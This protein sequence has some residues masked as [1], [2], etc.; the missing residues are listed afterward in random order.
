MKK[1]CETVPWP[2]PLPI[3]SFSLISDQH[4]PTIDHLLQTLILVL[5]VSLTKL[6]AQQLILKL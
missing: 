2:A 5:V 4:E 6:Q 3:L 1:H